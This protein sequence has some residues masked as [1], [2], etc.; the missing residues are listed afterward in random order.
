M[1]PVRPFWC[2]TYILESKKMG[3][4]YTSITNNLKEKGV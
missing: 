4:F 1:N 3:S 2:Y